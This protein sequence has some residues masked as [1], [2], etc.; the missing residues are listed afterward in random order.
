MNPS[1]GEDVTYLYV[2]LLLGT[3]W[4]DTAARLCSPTPS[5]YLC[6]CRWMFEIHLLL[7]LRGAPCRVN[8]LKRC[9]GVKCQEEARF[10]SFAP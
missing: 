9:L 6:C 3:N 10:H 7:A 8:V 5:T 1:G 2:R 4:R